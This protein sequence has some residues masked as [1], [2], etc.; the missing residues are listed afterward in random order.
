MRRL[1]RYLLVLVA[2]TVALAGASWARGYLLPTLARWLDVGVAPQPADYLF[3]LPG[4]EDTRPFVAAALVKAGYARGPASARQ[5]GAD[6][7]AARYARLHDAGPTLH[8][9]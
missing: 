5:S 7:A 1:R 8:D 4:G 2:A 3:V 9:S 6:V